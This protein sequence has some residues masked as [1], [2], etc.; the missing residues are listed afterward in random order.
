VREAGH[1]EPL[2][3]ALK[4]GLIDM[5]STDHAPH[6]PHEKHTSSIWDAAPG[7]PGVELSMRLML[8]EIARGRLSLPAYVRMACEAP[9]R[10]FG[11]YPRK[12]VLQPGSDGDIVLIDLA[13]RG[14]ISGRNLRSPGNVTPFEGRETIGAPVAAWVRGGLVAKDGAIVARSPVGRSVRAPGSP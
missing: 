13:R 8:T 7:F 1:A 14:R 5:I 6:L 11:L 2:W 9:A 10:A 4:S 3:Q 12:G